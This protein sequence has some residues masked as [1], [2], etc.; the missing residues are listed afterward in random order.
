M[1][2]YIQ[3]INPEAKIPNLAYQ[4]D[5]GIDLFSVEDTE[6]PSMENKAIATGIKIAIPEGYAGF[7]W[8][9]SGLALNN[10]IKTMAGVIDSGYRGEV[11]VVLFNLGKETYKI[12]K[13]AK[14]AQLVIMPIINYELEEVKELDNT[15]RGEKGF[16][17]SGLN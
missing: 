9:K 5:A 2:I 6:I 10:K 13:G 1:K 4:G 11:K 16:G 14:I 8:D 15:H 17:S 3:K 12:Q 7:V